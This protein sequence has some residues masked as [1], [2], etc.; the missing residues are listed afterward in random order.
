[1]SDSD[2]AKISRATYF[3]AALFKDLRAE[4]RGSMG[5]AW[6]QSTVHLAPDWLIDSPAG[7]WGRG[8]R[9]KLFRWLKN[10]PQ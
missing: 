5:T 9:G 7:Y 4:N 1:M 8:D 3:E 2:S 10:L 6:F